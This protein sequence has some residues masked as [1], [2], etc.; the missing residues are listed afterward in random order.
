MAQNN[1]AVEYDGQ[2]AQ[3]LS[4]MQDPDVRLFTEVASW[5]NQAIIEA[6]KEKAESE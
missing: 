2:I 3:S 5:H 6:K 4:D 1:W